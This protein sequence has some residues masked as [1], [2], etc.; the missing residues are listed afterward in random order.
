VLALVTGALLIA[1]GLFAAK[2]RNNAVRGP[3]WIAVSLVSGFAM[4]VLW[5]TAQA[6]LPLESMAHPIWAMAAAALDQPTSTFVSVDPY[7]T[8]THFMRL[9]TYAAIFVLAIRWGRDNARNVLK[10][11]GGAAAV[12]SAYGLMEQANGGAYILW[13]KK[14]AYHEALTSTFVSKNSFAAYAGIGLLCVLALLISALTRGQRGEPNWRVAIVEVTDTLA[15]GAGA[16]IVLGIIFLIAIPL[17]S[18]RAGTISV[19]IG[20]MVLLF[21]LL[22]RSGR[23]IRVAGV[24]VGS[25][26][27]VEMALR[28][29][30]GHLVEAFLSDTLQGNSLL[31]QALRSL[32]LSAIADEP[33]GGHGFGTFPSIFWRYRT[34]DIGHEFTDAHNMY[35]EHAAELGIP[36]TILMYAL[37]ALVAGVCLRGVYIRRR[38]NVY[39]A[40]AFAVTCLLGLHSLVDFSVKIP[41]VSV[42]FAA[43][44]GVGYAQAWPTRTKQRN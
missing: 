27:I 17:T 5:I 35:L 40:T 44:L 22:A 32:T 11:I 6:L 12:Y 42:T 23:T 18:S 33:W 13:F 28:A 4:L 37:V 2:E 3:R 21:L 31:R 38:G 39:P 24:L 1:D 43:L 14:W 26:V 15:R 7:L 8:M 9:T 10:V 36:A 19:A 25:I 30:G 29:T 34:P 20:M 41:A 16:Y